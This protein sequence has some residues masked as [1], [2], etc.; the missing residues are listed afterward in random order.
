MLYLYDYAQPQ[1]NWD[2]RN[3]NGNSYTTHS[4]NQHIPQ[5]RITVMK[6]KIKIINNSV[7]VDDYGFCT[8]FV[9]LTLSFPCSI[10]L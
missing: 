2:W 4:M 10:Y 7:V 3:V 8:I 9:L 6:E 5:V 1:D